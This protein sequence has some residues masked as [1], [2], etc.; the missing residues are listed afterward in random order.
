MARANVSRPEAEQRVEAW[1][2]SYERASAAFEQQKS[3][4]A[5]KAREVADA[6]AKAPSQ[7]ALGAAVALILGALAAA[8]AA[9]WPGARSTLSALS[10]DPSSRRSP[11]ACRPGDLG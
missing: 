6:A 1:V 4:A 5:A 7:A 10:A 8:M 9:C 3:E 2:Q 11:G